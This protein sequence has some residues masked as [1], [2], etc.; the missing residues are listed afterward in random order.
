M[1][2]TTVH[3]VIRDRRGVRIVNVRVAQQVDGCVLAE[4]GGRR[5]ERQRRGREKEQEKDARRV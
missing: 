1:Y 2:S 3:L 5:R 4:D